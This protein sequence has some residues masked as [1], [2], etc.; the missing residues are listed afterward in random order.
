MRQKFSIFHVICVKA[1]S[2]PQCARTLSKNVTIKT[3]HCGCEKFM[4]GLGLVNVW[5]AWLD[6]IKG[7]AL[8]K[9]RYSNS[10][11]CLGQSVLN[12]IKAMCED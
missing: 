8:Y 9:V 11:T 2:D 5:K 10:R 6:M 3:A 12:H 7:K 4:Q 1:S